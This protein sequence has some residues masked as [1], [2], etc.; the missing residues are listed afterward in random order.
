MSGRTT[1]GRPHK[2]WKIYR[3]RTSWNYILNGINILDHVHFVHAYTN[4]PHYMWDIQKTSGSKS[5]YRGEEV[6]GTGHCSVLSKRQFN[7]KALQSN[8]LQHHW[9]KCFYF[10]TKL[11]KINFFELTPFVSWM[12]H[13][14]RRFIITIHQQ[15]YIKRGLAVTLARRQGEPLYHDIKE[16]LVLL[17][18]S[19]DMDF[20]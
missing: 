15:H 8:R 14:K 1:I 9:S 20:I 16:M 12:H 7:W 18:N 17:L 19:N 6:L 13:I 2:S 11:H 10:H 4:T 5:N 3:L